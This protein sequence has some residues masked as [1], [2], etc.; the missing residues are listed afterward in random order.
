MPNVEPIIFKSKQNNVVVVMV[1]SRRNKLSRLERRLA[2]INTNIQSI[3]YLVSS[4][5]SV[6]IYL[7]W[8][9]STKIERLYILGRDY[10]PR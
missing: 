10:W 3:L 8:F 6:S 5:A 9:E 1:L 4:W 7:I 2:A